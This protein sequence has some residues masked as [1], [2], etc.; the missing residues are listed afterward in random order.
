MAART[1]APQGV[2]SQCGLCIFHLAQFPSCA[3]NECARA[4]ADLP[5]RSGARLPDA[6]SPHP[7]QKE[8]T[9]PALLPAQ[10]KKTRYL[11]TEV[12]YK[13]AKVPDKRKKAGYLAKKS[14]TFS[15]EVRYSAK[16]TGYSG[17]KAGYFFPEVPAQAKKTGYS[18]KK[19]GYSATFSGPFLVLLAGCSPKGYA[20]VENIFCPI[21]GASSAYFRV[22][23][24]PPQIVA[25]AF[26]V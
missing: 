23:N 3:I 24:M 11:A 9:L 10:A 25:A 12:R 20:R 19:A 8:R 14:G 4:G 16:K 22:F 13:A 17:M 18:A 2:F 5:T 1:P 26:G 6:V 21:H 7:P 15:A